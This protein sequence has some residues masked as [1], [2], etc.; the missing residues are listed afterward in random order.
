[1]RETAS[2]RLVAVRAYQPEHVDSL[3]EAVKESI[4][5]LSRYETWCHP[6]YTRDE[7]AAYVNWWRKM[8]QERKAYYFVV[9]E[10][11][12]REFLGSCGLSDLVREHKRAG[13]G[14]WTRS[15]RAGEG[16]ATDAARAVMH[17]GF[18]D[19][20][21]ERIEIETAVDNAA[22]RRIAEKLGCELEGVLRRR[23]ILPAGPTD[24]AIYS[25][26]RDDRR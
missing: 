4:P 25:L 7:A 6:R 24:T 21:L 1:M 12:S 20:A 18:D 26:I 2:G 23:Q 17:L 11:E 22:S 15:S 9:E 14:F 3:Y 10:L 5:D 13:L 8:W 19:L 16:F